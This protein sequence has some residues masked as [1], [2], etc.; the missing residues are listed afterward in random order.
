MDHDDTQNL[1]RNPSKRQ[2]FSRLLSDMT[3][4]WVRRDSDYSYECIGPADVADHY[5]M[6]QVGSHKVIKVSLVALLS[7]WNHI[8]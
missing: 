1:T 3:G 5:Q 6:Q 7:K 2:R 4:V 8:P